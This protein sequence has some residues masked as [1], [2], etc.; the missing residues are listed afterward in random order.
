MVTEFWAQS[1]GIRVI[2]VSTGRQASGNRKV[3][4]PTLRVTTVMKSNQANTDRSR[5]SGGRCAVGCRK[6]KRRNG[7]LFAG[8]P[9]EK[10]A[11]AFLG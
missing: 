3:F 4:L 7:E 1:V 6:A 8:L 10:A 5:P 2:S 11:R 9:S